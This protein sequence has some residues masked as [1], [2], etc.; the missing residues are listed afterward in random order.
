MSEILNLA[1]RLNKRIDLQAFTATANG[2]G[3]FT[4]VWNTA[5]TVWAEVKPAGGREIFA[6]D[7]VEDVESVIF[8]IRYMDG[9]SPNMRISFNGNYYNIRSVINTGLKNIMLEIMGERM[10]T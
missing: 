8:T 1:S 6:G 10:D 2:A 3:G 5:A 9:I 4:T 7:M